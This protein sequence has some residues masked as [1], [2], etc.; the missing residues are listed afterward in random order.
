[1]TFKRF[2]ELWRSVRW[3]VIRNPRIVDRGTPRVNAAIRRGTDGDWSEF[4]KAKRIL[5]ER[6]RNP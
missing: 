6:D 5:A 4:D 3:P 2:K 1:M